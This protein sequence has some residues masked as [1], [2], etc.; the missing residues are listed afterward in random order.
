M[1][2]RLVVVALLMMAVGCFG[3]GMAVAGPPLWWISL[4]SVVLIWCSYVIASR[5]LRERE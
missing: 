2:V 3:A 4:P 5:T 1:N